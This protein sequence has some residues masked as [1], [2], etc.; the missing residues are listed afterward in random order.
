MGF[1]S[2]LFPWGLILQAVAL[3]HFLRRRPDGYWFWIIL[4]LGPLGAIAY[5]AM[6]IVPDLGL[7]TQVYDAMGRRKRIRLLEAIV[8]ENP[9]TG[10]Y[11][12]LAGLYL[13]EGHFAKARDAYDKAITPRDDQ[14]DPVYR[15]AIA[16]IH[17]GRFD[18]AV[19]DLEQVTAHDRKYD[20]RRAIALLAHAYAHTDQPD[21]AEALFQEAT[22]TSTLSETYCHYAQFLNAQ[23]RHDEARE[24]AQKVL[25]KKA[26]MPRY[27]RQRERRW[28]AEA[29]RMLA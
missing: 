18:D 4:F 1:F 14:P 24:W 13:D 26:T 2:F 15:R 3:V 11:D 6:E 22:T 23:G 20:L 25:D 19:R 7:L 5:I 17:L 12:E 8:K 29:K 9:A 10:N 21:R 16:S 28:L 27:L